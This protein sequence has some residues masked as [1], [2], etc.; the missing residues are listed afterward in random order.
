ML[1]DMY[2]GSGGL[3]VERLIKCS[4]ASTIH[5]AVIFEV[6]C[7]WSAKRWPHE[8][9]TSQNA[10]NLCIYEDITLGQM[11]R[12]RGFNSEVT[13]SMAHRGKS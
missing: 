8:R 4:F 6:V 10:I 9:H 5:P 1:S 7:H 11:G 12:L 13:N 2:Q 3:Q